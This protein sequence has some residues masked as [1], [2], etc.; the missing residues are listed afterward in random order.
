MNRVIAGITDVKGRLA[1]Y[2]MSI[3]SGGNQARQPSRGSYPR[4]RA[5]F[6]LRLERPKLTGGWMGLSFVACVVLS[7]LAS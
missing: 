3:A 6:R 4:T 5:F 7:R 1:P 2:Q